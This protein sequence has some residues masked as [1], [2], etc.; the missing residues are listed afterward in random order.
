MPILGI[1]ATIIGIWVEMRRWQ[2]VA[3]EQEH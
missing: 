3:E 2:G 1:V